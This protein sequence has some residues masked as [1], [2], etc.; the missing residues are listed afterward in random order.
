MERCR[1]LIAEFGIDDIRFA[2]CP[3]GPS[4]KISAVGKGGWIVERYALIDN[5]YEEAR[6]A[7]EKAKKLQQWYHINDSIAECKLMPKNIEVKRRSRKG[8]NKRYRVTRP[9]GEGKYASLMIFARDVN[10]CKQMCKMMGFEP[11]RIEAMPQDFDDTNYY[12]EVE[13]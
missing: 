4:I 13:L 1:E 6:S 8:L 5:L 3:Y 7:C 2:H 12:K 11:V 10:E 9:Y